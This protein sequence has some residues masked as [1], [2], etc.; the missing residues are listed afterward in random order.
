MSLIEIVTTFDSV[1]NLI[2]KKVEM[3]NK[4][5]EK[6]IAA[7][8]GKERALDVLPLK[9]STRGEIVA[10]QARFLGEDYWFEEMK[11]ELLIYA[12]GVIAAKMTKR[13]YFC[14]PLLDGCFS[15]NKFPH[16]L[17]DAQTIVDEAFGQ[18]T[19]VYK[20][21]SLKEEYE[22]PLAKKDLDRLTSTLTGGRGSNDS[23]V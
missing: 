2:K 19:A 15:C 14:C 9:T 23:N 12:Y 7:T 17:P 11:Q 8:E 10:A 1:S 22:P 18:F 6:R 16:R 21:N 20:F 4:D 5:I 13:T 3:H